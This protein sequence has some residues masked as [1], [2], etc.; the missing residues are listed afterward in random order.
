MDRPVSQWLTAARVAPH[1][2]A[3]WPRVTPALT[4]LSM[5][6]I[7]FTV[8]NG[9]PMTPTS[10]PHV[11][12]LNGNLPFPPFRLHSVPTSQSLR[13]TFDIVKAEEMR[14]RAGNPSYA[15]IATAMGLK[16]RQAVGHWFRGRGE[17]DVQQMKKMAKAL[18]CHWLELV[19]EDAVVI[20]REDE[21]ARVERMRELGEDD[22]RE[23][24]A[25]LAVKAA[26]RDKPD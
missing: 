4:S 10:Q 15:K 5:A 1:A 13:K 9:N 21:R 23:L 24:D 7:R 19:K 11:T 17:P 2:A 22:L 18:G 26:S 20:Y 12:R 3:I 25:Y 14:E 16:S 6:L 8:T